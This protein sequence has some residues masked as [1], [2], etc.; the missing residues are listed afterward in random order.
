MKRVWLF[1]LFAAACGDD[2]SSQGIAV[3]P[4]WSQ[5]LAPVGPNVV[6]H[7][8]VWSRGGL[9]LWDETAAAPNAQVI[10]LVADLQPGVL[11]FPGGTRAMRY[12]FDQAIGP[13]AQRTPQCDPFTGMTDATHYGLDEFLRV[14]EQTHADVTLVAPWVDGTPQE[15]AALVAYVNADASSTVVIG[16]DANG[17]D[18]GTAGSWAMRRAQNGHAAPYSIHYLEIGNEQYHDLAVGPP[19]SCGRMS[20]FRQDERWVGTM[21]IP[22]TAA[23]HATQVALYATLVHAVD[24]A[25]KVGASAYSTYDG[26]SNAADA[27][28]D[29]D[30]RMGTGDAWDRRLVQDGGALDFFIIHPY[31]FSTNDFRITLAEKVRK[32]IQDLHALAPAKDVAITEYGFLFDGGTLLNA[33]VSADMVRVAAEEK[34]LLALRHILIEDRTDEP[35]ADSAAIAGPDHALSPGYH[36]MRLLAHNLAPNA[37]K[38]T[39]NDPDVVALATRDDSGATLGILVIDRRTKAG[40]TRAVEV[41]LPSGSFAGNQTLVTAPQLSATD[42]SVTETP[43]TGSGTLHVMLPPHSLV[44]LRLAKI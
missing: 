19:N 12:H 40:P 21:R 35:F 5:T 36:V 38:V 3:T 9:G 18:W 25:I 23:D 44:V 27:I 39:S 26:H 34:V 22:T 31:D 28:A 43:T 42:V 37:V 32:T 30:A 20:V 1:A 24:P 14:A 10:S 15:A 4:D 13:V 8:A 11:R 16:A 33:L 7:N 29:L 17:K 6:G 41:A 2:G